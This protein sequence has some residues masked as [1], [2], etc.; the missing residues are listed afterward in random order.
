MMNDDTI[1]YNPFEATF[2]DWL[3]GSERSIPVSDYQQA[4]AESTT[5]LPHRHCA[6]LGVPAGSTIGHA[7]RSLVPLY[8]EQTGTEYLLSTGLQF[9]SD[10]ESLAWWRRHRDS[11]DRVTLTPNDDGTWRLT[12]AG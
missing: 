10:D 6:E 4:L 3:D 11:P 5:P 12:V 8:C 2:L 9:S 7:V 1:H